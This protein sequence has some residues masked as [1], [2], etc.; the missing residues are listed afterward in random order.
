[1]NTHI[2]DRFLEAWEAFRLAQAEA[3]AATSRMNAAADLMEGLRAELRSLEDARVDAA[4]VTQAPAASPAAL[5]QAK[6]PKKPATCGE[7]IPC[8]QCG[9]PMSPKNSSGEPRKFCSAAC[10]GR[11]NR[12]GKAPG[13]KTKKILPEPLAAEVVEPPVAQ[14][15]RP[16]PA[17]STPAPAAASPVRPPVPEEGLTLGDIRRRTGISFDTL[18]DRVACGTLKVLNPDERPPRYTPESVVDLERSYKLKGGRVG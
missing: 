7:M 13:P 8:P 11:Y 15:E 9:N 5:H 4:P 18:K 10:A 16:E 12:T 17:A 1:M 6:A 14:P 2:V 3:D